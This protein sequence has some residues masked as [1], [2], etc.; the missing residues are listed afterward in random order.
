MSHVSNWIKNLNVDLLI[1]YHMIVN[2][3]SV[4]AIEG[5]SLKQAPND[6]RVQNI[7]L[8]KFTCRK[9]FIFHSNLF[10]NTSVST[11]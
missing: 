2:V 9:N 3:I 8:L 6:E 4:C 10:T 11:F 7:M 1:G 5:Y